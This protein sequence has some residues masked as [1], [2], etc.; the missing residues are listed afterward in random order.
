MVGCKCIDKARNGKICAEA[1]QRESQERQIHIQLSR[2]S[3]SIL[4]LN[5][6]GYSRGLSDIGLIHTVPQNFTASCICFDLLLAEN[7]C[8]NLWCRCSLESMKRFKNLQDPIFLIFTGSFHY[9]FLRCFTDLILKF[10]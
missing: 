9:L 10:K 4:V 6:T 1:K 7:E 5:G 3:F 8:K 2:V